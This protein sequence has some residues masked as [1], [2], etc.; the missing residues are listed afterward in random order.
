VGF[1]PTITASERAKTVHALDRAA[2]AIGGCYVRTCAYLKAVITKLVN[3]V[4]RQ[5][6]KQLD[7]QTLL[8]INEGTFVY[9]TVRQIISGTDFHEG[10]QE[11][12]CEGYIYSVSGKQDRWWYMARVD[13]LFV[14]ISMYCKLN[15]SI[16]FMFLD[17]VT[18]AQRVKE[19]PG[20]YG[21]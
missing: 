21:V 16:E 14:D 4:K 19:L 15:D 2:S 8:D 10:T 1:E 11:R 6:R 17:Y 9:L 3:N 7:R 5:K 12:A 18:I 13:K 20:F